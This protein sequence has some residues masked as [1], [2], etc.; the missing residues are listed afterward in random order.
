M[1]S[2]SGFFD[3]LFANGSTLMMAVLV[4]LATAILSF[5]VMAAVRVRGAVKRRTAGIAALSGQGGHGRVEEPATLT[6]SGV[7]AAQKILDYAS[8]HYGSAEKGDAKVLRQRLIRAGIYDPRAVGYFFVVRLGLAI[9]GA[10]MMVGNFI[11]YRLV[12]FRI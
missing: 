2:D 6:Q 3:A 12:N 7:K 11:M 10:W 4:F 5:G 9:A 8:K 1:D